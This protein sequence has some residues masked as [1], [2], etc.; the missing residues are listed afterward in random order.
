L[1][2]LDFIIEPALPGIQFFHTVLFALLNIKQILEYFLSVIQVCILP[3][4]G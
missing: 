3:Y 2:F 4:L 1:G